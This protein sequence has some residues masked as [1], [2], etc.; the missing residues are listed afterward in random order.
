MMRNYI[1]TLSIHRNMFSATW[2]QDCGVGGKMSDPNSD[3]SKIS[4][5]RFLNTKWMEFGCRDFCSI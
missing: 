5:S 1:A 3:L 2:T 4:D